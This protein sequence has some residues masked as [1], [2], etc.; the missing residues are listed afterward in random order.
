MCMICDDIA[1][2]DIKK[3]REQVERESNRP[4]SIFPTEHLVDIT[5]QLDKLERRLSDPKEDFRLIK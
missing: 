4:R 2:G 1:R 5:L 3:A